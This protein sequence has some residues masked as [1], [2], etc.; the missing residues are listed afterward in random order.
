MDSEIRE[1]ISSN[2]KLLRKE[3]KISQFE[4]AEMADLSEQTII[5][6]EGQRLWPSDKTIVKMCRALNVDVCRLFMP[7]EFSAGINDEVIKRLES[8]VAKRIKVSLD[9]TLSAFIE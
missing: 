2:L 4:L 6:I 9:D 3:K 8:S 1:R 7:H 5:S